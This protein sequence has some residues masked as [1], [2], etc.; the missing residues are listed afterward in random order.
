MKNEL[1]KKINKKTAC[2]GIFGLGYVGL[3][4]AI[5]YAEENFKVIGFDVDL[6]KIKQLSKKNSYFDIILIA[7]DHNKF[8]YSM[9]KKNAKLIIDTRAVYSGKHK[10]IFKA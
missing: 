4:L 9:I 6:N 5:R 2:I 3:P 7:T 8:D 10:N 1:I